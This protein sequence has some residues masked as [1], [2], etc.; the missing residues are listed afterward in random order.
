MTKTVSTRSNTQA[1]K[2][3]TDREKP[4][5]VFKNNLTQL[6]NSKDEIKVVNFYGDPGIGK[7]ALLTELA[8]TLD[9]DFPNI[10]KLFYDFS[11]TENADNIINILRS[12][13][14]ILKESYNFTFPFFDLVA[15]TYEIKL[16]KKATRPE[17]ENIL[18][19]SETF[20]LAKDVISEIPL[21][22]NISKIINLVQIAERGKNLAKK[23]LQDKKFATRL[24]EIEQKTPAEIEKE[25]SLYFAADLS[26]NLTKND[27]KLVI[28]LDTYEAIINDFFINAK[29][30]NED[31]FTGP[32]GLIQ[33]TK[34]TLWIIAGREKL[35]WIEHN[36][37]WKGSLEQHIL[38]TLVFE[39]SD[40]FLKT[41][42]IDDAEL[43][44]RLHNLTYGSPM[45]LDL[46]V[47]I[48]Y[49]LKDAGKTPTIDDFGRN[50]RALSDRFFAYM[51]DADKDLV[52][53]FSH[54]DYWTD[55]TAE[56]L[57]RDNLGN[58]SPT[59]YEK[60]KTLSFVV[61]ENGKYSI[62]ES[63]RPII[64]ANTPKSAH[65]KYLKLEL[66]KITTELEQAKKNSTLSE[67]DEGQATKVIYQKAYKRFVKITGDEDSCK[68]DIIKAQA[69]MNIKDI[70]SLA[71]KYPKDDEVIALLQKAIRIHSPDY[72]NSSKLTYSLDEY[73]DLRSISEEIFKPTSIY[74]AKLYVDCPKKH[75]SYRD[76]KARGEA[77]ALSYKGDS[78]RVH[79]LA[80]LDS[81]GLNEL[82]GE[83]DKLN[84]SIY[85]ANTIKVRRILDL[86]EKYPE[87]INY[88]VL[89]YLKISFG[90]QLGTEA[91]KLI[92]DFFITHKNLVNDSTDEDFL[93]GY[94]E[95]IREALG[96]VVNFNTIFSE[97]PELYDKANATLR[98]ILP[99]Y[100]EVFGKDSQI[101]CDI[102]LF[103]RKK[104]IRNDPTVATE[105]L[106]DYKAYFPRGS[107]EYE[108]A[109]TVLLMEIRA[110]AVST[111]EKI[112]EE[113]D[114]LIN[115]LL[116][117][118]LIYLD[119]GSSRI[120]SAIWGLL[121]SAYGSS[122]VKV[123][124]SNNLLKHIQRII[125]K[126]HLTKQ[127]GTTVA[128]IAIA[129]FVENTIIFQISLYKETQDLG[130]K[131]A[132]MYSLYREVESSFINH[133]T[134]LFGY[135]HWKDDE[136]ER[137]LGTI[138]DNLKPSSLKTLL[139][140]LIDLILRI[141]DNYAKTVK[142]E[143]IKK[144][145][146]KTLFYKKNEKYEQLIEQTK[147]Y[148]SLIEGIKNG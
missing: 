63:I 40:R 13:E 116:D 69:S 85:E 78:K 25:L 107:K 128:K 46:C 29:I 108:S 9:N 105:I 67:H 136:I 31:F 92:F 144:H 76:L 99:R 83:I 68:L 47:D 4:R 14:Q 89:F 81:L 58:F 59:L 48:Y 45:Y 71:R 98:Y 95:I 11:T 35:R 61:E 133:L 1:V 74:L 18:E 8:K 140:Y 146:K 139:I 24:R 50:T 129:S 33:N 115:Y 117:E 39:D 126:C 138:A 30:A 49:A 110:K 10:L 87:E 97:T 6:R 75:D 118:S 94:F 36:E 20:N 66:S 52:Q 142:P 64:I 82:N 12:L 143:Y 124:F 56:K 27:Q 3:F 103:I 2:I 119:D 77:I 86:L 123:H 101:V 120:W 65:E 5:E 55:E 106:S 125:P 131:G 148:I 111:P 42:G 43:R 44:K 79:I 122:E 80:L 38:E 53:L 135:R 21:I 70:A 84:T 130:I 34:N 7:S 109:L 16:G 137:K 15:Y 41:A 60:I 96:G 62:N 100:E 102:R 37:S 51:S 26:D 147:K 32:S 57:V 23:R 113:D 22:N 134:D 28:F 91:Q 132:Q 104:Q 112:T 72:F 19:S 141:P 73:E 88:R 93:N 121:E 127:G 54:V 114:K 90:D 145:T 17:L